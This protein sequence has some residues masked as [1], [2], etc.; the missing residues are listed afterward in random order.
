MSERAKPE[1]LFY[2]CIIKRE[3]CDDH[4]RTLRT[5]VRFRTGLGTGPQRVADGL[6]VRCVAARWALSNPVF[7]R[8]T[9]IAASH[10]AASAR[11]VTASAAEARSFREIASFDGLAKLPAKGRLTR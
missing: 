1:G 3:C 5:I 7:R 10:L 2:V 11:V 8:S 9:F 4:V 6:G